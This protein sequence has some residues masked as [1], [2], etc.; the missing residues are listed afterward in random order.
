ME[1]ALM[2]SLKVYEESWDSE[3]FWLKLVAIWKPGT[4][5]R[6][7]MINGFTDDQGFFNRSIA[8]L[9]LGKF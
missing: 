6:V 2:M 7:V 8:S 9:G 5:W 4:I 3:V 1:S